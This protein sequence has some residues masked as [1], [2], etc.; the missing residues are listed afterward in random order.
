MQD[1]PLLLDSNFPKDLFQKGA[2]DV[3]LRTPFKTDYVGPSN[4]QLLRAPR[5]KVPVASYSPIDCFDNDGCTIRIALLPQKRQPLNVSVNL[6]ASSRRRHLDLSSV[7]RKLFS[8]DLAQTHPT[9]VSY[10]HLTLPTN[11]EV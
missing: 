9:P 1:S 4:E 10:T 11:R 8:P 7:R 6:G 5:K 2:M 3:V